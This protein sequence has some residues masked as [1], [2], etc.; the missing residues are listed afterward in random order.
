MEAYADH[1]ATTTD[2]SVHDA[3]KSAVADIK[4]NPTLQAKLDGSSGTAL[5][6]QLRQHIAADPS[7]LAAVGRP[8]REIGSDA[9]IR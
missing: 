5:A 1:L 7:L 3:F 9:K 8:M 6:T 4:A 2:S